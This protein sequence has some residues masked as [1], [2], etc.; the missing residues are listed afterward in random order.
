MSRPALDLTPE[1]VAEYRR[2]ARVRWEREQQ[3]RARRLERAWEVARAAAQLL[4]ER[5]GA[6]RVVVFG[7]LVHE[8][9]FTP[10]S[11]IDIAVWGICPEDTFR[12]IGAV[13]DMGSEIEVNLVDVGACRPSLLTVIEEE[14]VDL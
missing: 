7:S 13:M 1:E 8:G 14:G 6:T 10:W 12:A 9:C 2:S 3:E 5:F 11:D 4:K